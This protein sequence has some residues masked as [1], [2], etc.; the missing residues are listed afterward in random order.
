MTEIQNFNMIENT[1][2]SIGLTKK[3]SFLDNLILLELTDINLINAIRDSKEFELDFKDKYSH[4]TAKQIYM[5]VSHQLQ[6]YSNN[7]DK[8]LGAFKVLYKK[9]DKHKWGRVFPRKSLGFTSFSRV[10]R[11][12]LMKDFYIDFDLK[13]AQ[14]EIIKNIC[15]SNNIQLESVNEYCNNRDNILNDVMKEYD[16]DRKIAKNLFLSLAFFGDFKGWCFTNN[17]KNT[18]TLT[19]IDSYIKDIK[20]FY[21]IV[22]KENKSLYETVKKLGN[23][24]TK[25]SLLSL[26]LQEYETRIMEVVIYWLC[27]KTDVMKFKDSKFNIGTYEFDGIKLLKEN[28]NKYGIDKLK[29]DLE[30]VI[31]NELGFIINFEEKPIDGWIDIQYTKSIKL[32]IEPIETN[33]DDIKNGVWDDSQATKKMFKLYPFWKY[34]LGLLYV[35]NFE[36]GLWTNCKA[37]QRGIIQKFI[38]DLRILLKDLQGN[39]FLSKMSYGNALCKI[40]IIIQ[41]IESECVDNEWLKQKEKSSLGMLLFN[42]GYID[43]K[44]GFN[45]YDKDTYSFNPEIV[46]MEKI[47]RD[48]K[49]LDEKQLDYMESLRNKFFYNPLGEQL[50]DYYILQLARGLM[51][52]LIKKII[53]GLGGTNCGKSK[54]T[55]ALK[56]SF[57]GYYGSF[58]AENLLYTKS[59][60][61]E[62]AKLRW[63]LLLRYKR[64]IISNEMKTNTTINGNML[65]KISSGGDGITGRF[66]GNNETEFVPHGLFV[67][68]ANDIPKIAPYDPAVDGRIRVIS[69]KKQFVDEVEDEENEL[70]KDNNIDNE[71]MTDDFKNAFLMMFLKRYV[72]FKE[73]G[74]IDEP[75]EVINGKKEWIE[76]TGNNID[77][78]LNDFEITNNEEDFILSEDIKIWTDDKKLHISSTKIAMEIKKYCKKNNYNNVI[79]KVKKVNKR[80]IMAWFGIKAITDN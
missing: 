50:G 66:H 6:E 30:N 24:N 71:I 54:L 25:G 74:D 20:K 12:T 69:Y 27:N 15:I 53:F 36:T 42:N 38:N 8:K 31:K 9:T 2:I 40:N 77:L 44:N 34:C 75:E 28:V 37:V 59:S 43:L 55:D 13:N 10:I 62:G 60:T 57:S 18:K 49:P 48:F 3:T 52:D 67:C 47:D 80:S 19:I 79:N 51:G 39:I 41:M 35:F 21:K 1:K 58:N 23:K 11:N 56:N 68:M 76:E 65:K 61:D 73:N 29:T 70:L 16:V 7:Y 46:F 5:N 32:N 45:F 72:D 17:I 78:F 64:L 14:P 4:K 63:A 33:D 22:K 26:Y